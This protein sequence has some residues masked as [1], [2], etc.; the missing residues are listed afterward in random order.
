L[1]SALEPLEP[2]EPP[3]PLDGEL[4]DAAGFGALEPPELEPL[5]EDDFAAAG[6]GAGFAPPEPPEGPPAALATVRT[7]TEEDANP[8]DIAEAAVEACV[9]ESSPEH[10][11]QSGGAEKYRH[12][13]GPA[14]PDQHRNQRG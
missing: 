11:H 8:C 13:A 2:P 3:D 5:P 12:R 14:Q 1:L 9:D 7:A 4:E 10:P 6:F